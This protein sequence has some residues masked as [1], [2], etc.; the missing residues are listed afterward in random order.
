MTRRSAQSKELRN[1]IVNMI[2]LLL[3]TGALAAGALV[4]SSVRGATIKEVSVT[5]LAH[6]DIR[7]HNSFDN[8]RV[9]EPQ[10]AQASV[11]SGGTAV[12]SFAPASVTRLQITLA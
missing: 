11:K 6:K 9:I 12:Y 2:R 4:A 7:A 1:S 3:I 10:S 5:T 8:P